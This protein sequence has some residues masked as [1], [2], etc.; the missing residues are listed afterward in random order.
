MFGSPGKEAVEIQVVS[1]A[2]RADRPSSATG[3]S[4]VGDVL[5]GMPLRARAR[6][7]LVGVALFSFAPKGP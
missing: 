7:A 3:P 6:L 4:A 2:Q 5:L 1:A